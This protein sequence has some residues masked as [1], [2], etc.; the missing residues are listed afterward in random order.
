MKILGLGALGLA[1][2][3]AVSACDNGSSTPTTTA[4]EPPATTETLTGVVP[5]TVNGV[6]QNSFVK[7]TVGQAGTVSITLTSAVETLP[8]GAV[9]PSVFVG[10]GV[11]VQDATGT[12]CSLSTSITLVQAAP[13]TYT[14]SFLAGAAACIQVSDQTVLTGPVTYTLIVTHPS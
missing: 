6:Q 7:F 2:V 1:L 11:G 14:I 12:S 5:A 8:G 10:L 13:T 9:N 3:L 4:P